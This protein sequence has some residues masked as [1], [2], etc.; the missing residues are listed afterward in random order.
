MEMS[1]TGIINKIENI[2]AYSVNDMPRSY[3]AM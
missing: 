3:S 1:N 2:P